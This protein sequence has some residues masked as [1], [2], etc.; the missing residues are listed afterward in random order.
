ML[1]YGDI[2]YM[3]A[4]QSSLKMLDSVYH[5]ALRFV[6]N[7]SFRTHHCSL[8]ESVGW[9]S[10]H[11][12]RLEHWYI[13]LF[14]AILCKLPP[15]LCSLLTPK[16]TTG[17]CNL[18]SYGQI[19]YDIPR[20]WTV[21]GESAFKFFAPSSWYKLQNHLKLDY[22]P[23]LRQF[24]SRIKD[25]WSTA[26][27]C[28]ATERCWWLCGDDVNLPTVFFFCFLLSVFVVYFKYGTFVLLSW[29]G[30]PWKRDSESQWDF[31]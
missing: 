16:V 14:K 25:Y 7:S 24:N 3:H 21:F 23:T 17:K 28:A 19:M 6:T 20:M 12:R 9:P 18:R 10:L 29:P 22:L 26:C 4:N 11:N 8:Y 5:A 31:S 1:D 27:T 2:L 15:Y 30:L 13:F